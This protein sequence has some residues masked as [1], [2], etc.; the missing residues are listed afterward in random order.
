M[1]ALLSRKIF[2]GLVLISSLF[3]ALASARPSDIDTSFGRSGLLQAP[4]Q[5]GLAAAGIAGAVRLSS[6]QYLAVGA[7]RTGQLNGIAV[8]RY[9]A[10][11]TRDATYSENI[12]ADFTSLDCLGIQALPTGKFIVV[13]FTYRQVVLLRL[14]ADGSRDR[15]FGYA[16]VKR[17]DF[18]SFLYFFNI[19]LVEH[20]MDFKVLQDGGLVLTGLA[21]VY[22]SNSFQH[23]V[24]FL[25]LNSEGDW[26]G[27][28]GDK[29]RAFVASDNYF[30]PSSLAEDHSGRLLLG[31]GS[32][33]IRLLANGQ[34][35]DDTF[36]DHGSINLSSHDSNILVSSLAVQDDNKPVL[37]GYSG[38]NERA[39]VARF[40]ED[41]SSDISFNGSGYKKIE[42]TTGH[43]EPFVKKVVMH[44][45]KILVAGDDGGIISAVSSLFVQQLN[46]DGSVDINFSE[47]GQSITSSVKKRFFME[48]ASLLPDGSIMELIQSSVILPE[49]LSPSSF[50][51]IHLN[52]MGQRDPDFGNQGFKS[53]VVNGLQIKSWRAMGLQSDG[54]VIAIGDVDDEVLPSRNNM[55]LARY[56]ADGNLDTTFGGAGTGIVRTSMPG[57][58]LMV[59][60]T[61]LQTDNKIVVCGDTGYYGSVFVARFTANGLIDTGFFNKGWVLMDLGT[62]HGTSSK[63]NARQS[64]RALVDLGAGRIGFAGKTETHTHDNDGV[65][66]HQET[67]LGVLNPDNTRQFKLVFG[68]DLSGAFTELAG[69][70]LVAADSTHMVISATGFHGTEISKD[71]VTARFNVSDLSLD[72]SYGLGGYASVAIGNS[73]YSEAGSLLRLPDNKLLALANSNEGQV[74][75]LNAANAIRFTSNGLVDTGFANN[76]QF[77]GTFWTSSHVYYAPIGGL[78][79]DGKLMMVSGVLS[80]REFHF[81]LMRLTADGL[82]DPGFN[83]SGRRLSENIFGKSSYP[84][85]FL[86]MPDGKFWVAGSC[87]GVACIVRYVGDSAVGTSLKSVS[88]AKAFTIPDSFGP[89]DMTPVY[90]R[91]S[92]CIQSQTAAINGRKAPL[93]AV[94]FLRQSH[95]SLQKVI[96][97][98]HR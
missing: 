91:F 77:S 21:D 96:S 90:L 44:G 62:L 84:T 20:D 43:V 18:P 24:V 67:I 41:G 13:G 10:N 86:Q 57:A 58:D 28:F 74:N 87:G 48:G 47:N 68:H 80:T 51:M 26:D 56:L 72:G 1:V 45:D 33:L 94:D 31:N 60:S 70:G 64:C 25:K 39:F 93:N 54:K 19:G 89:L 3:S 30:C 14:N 53:D 85:S 23:G 11:G 63:V 22:Q 8:R 4:W 12:Q 76:G 36:G 50:T 5:T 81:G 75:Y 98:C 71:L 79:T 37:G 78:T 32:R 95:D 49:G 46:S 7:L 69:S 6:G 9:S 73:Y 66:S 65:Y 52:A 59:Y 42:M 2:L 92:Q 15:S 17:V 29:G 55:V 97:G 83:Y 82:P 27:S 16:G 35:L 88:E 38:S 34:G 61:M 40:N